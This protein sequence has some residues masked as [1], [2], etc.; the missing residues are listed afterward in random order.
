VNI[1]EM[2][3]ETGIEEKSI[4]YGLEE[5]AT[6]NPFWKIFSIMKKIALPFMQF[7]DLPPHKLHGVVTRIE[8]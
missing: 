6:E 4:F 7:H 8:M 2:L 3:K 5:I 1:E